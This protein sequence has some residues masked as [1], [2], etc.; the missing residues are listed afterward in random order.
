MHHSYKS[1]KEFKDID[2]EKQSQI[3]KVS[4]MRL[5]KAKK[6]WKNYLY[7]L[8]FMLLIPA[9]IYFYFGALIGNGSFRYALLFALY[10]I[11]YK[12]TVH[13][14]AAS[15]LPY[16]RGCLENGIT[17]VELENLKNVKKIN[18]IKFGV[19]TGLAWG[20]PFAVAMQFIDGFTGSWLVIIP[21]SLVGGLFFGGS[22][23]LW[24]NAIYET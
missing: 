11:G 7:S 19:F 3:L 23:M 9:F 1:I 18:Y 17:E 5:W 12:I 4:G 22:L 24:F 15:L 21:I 6:Q 2:P 10:L 13:L 16:I 14:K 8:V 20:L